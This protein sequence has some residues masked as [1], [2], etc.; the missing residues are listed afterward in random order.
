MCRLVIALVLSLLL[1]PCARAQKTAAE[2][3]EEAEAAEMHR[4]EVIVL[5]RETAHAIQLGN[6]TFFQRVYGDDYTGTNEIGQ[7]ISKATLIRAV[8]TSE[9][10]YASVV[11]SDI[12][13]RFFQETAVVQTLWSMR[14]TRNGQFLTRQVRVIHVY[15]N[16][17]RGWQVVA[18]QQTALPGEGH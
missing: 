9:I 4:Q 15:I 8:Q 17:P 11:A 6:P 1:Y 16:G 18:G 3:R 14:G 7:S 5:E 10:K 12:R 2:L 13:V